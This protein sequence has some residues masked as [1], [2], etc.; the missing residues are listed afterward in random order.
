[1]LMNFYK[2]FT[3]HQTDNEAGLYRIFY[4][5]QIRFYFFITRLHYTTTSKGAA[6]RY[7]IG[8]FQITTNRQPSC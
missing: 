1:M 3:A 5:V 8:I 2:N 7:L 6:Q 4:I